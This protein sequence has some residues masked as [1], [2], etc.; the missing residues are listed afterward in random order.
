MASPWWSLLYVKISMIDAA[1]VRMK[2]VATFVDW[3]LNR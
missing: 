3:N 2:F 1:I